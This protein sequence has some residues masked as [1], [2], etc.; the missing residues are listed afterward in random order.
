ML[1]EGSRVP[2]GAACYADVVS[3]FL[4]TAVASHAFVLLR[5]F[6]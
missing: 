6:V 1:N 4:L 5:H 3:L 2:L